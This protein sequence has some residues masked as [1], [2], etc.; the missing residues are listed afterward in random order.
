MSDYV[1]P[2]PVESIH[3]RDDDDDDDDDD[4]GLA[5]EDEAAQARADLG[6]PVRWWAK[7]LLIVHTSSRVR[8]G[9]SFYA[10]LW[11]I[12]I[13]RAIVSPMDAAGC[14]AESHGMRQKSARGR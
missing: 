5:R 12:W 7:R 13:R 9:W 14:A 3:R 8:N 2:S 4:D 6:V 1:F 10:T 11:S